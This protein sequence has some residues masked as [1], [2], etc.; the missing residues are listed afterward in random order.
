MRTYERY[1][2]EA[3]RL[4]SVTCDRC[5]VEMYRAPKQPSGRLD[6][7]GAHHEEQMKYWVRGGYD[8]CMECLEGAQAVLVAYVGK[9]P[10]R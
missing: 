6:Y 3:N 2:T 9:K 10:S 4:T 7:S 1:K 8:L 5:G